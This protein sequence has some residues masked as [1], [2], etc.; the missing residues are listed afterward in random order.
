MKTGGVVR[1]RIQQIDT[2]SF[3]L[4]LLLLACDWVED[5]IQIVNNFLKPAR[6]NNQKCQAVELS[7]GVGENINNS[8]KALDFCHVSLR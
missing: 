3:P 4:P 7:S 1:C 8:V 5:F 6:S 2:N